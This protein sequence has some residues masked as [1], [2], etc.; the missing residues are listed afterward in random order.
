MVINLGWWLRWVQAG[1]M[2][3]WRRVHGVRIFHKICSCEIRETL[4]EQV[5]LI[6]ER[7][8]QLGWLI[9]AWP[10]CSR[11]DWRGES[12][13]YRHGKA[14]QRSSKDKVRRLH[15][16]PGLIP[17][18]YGASR[19]AK[20]C[21]KRQVLRLLRQ[22]PHVRKTIVKR[23]WRPIENARGLQITR[24]GAFITVYSSLKKYCFCR[25]FHR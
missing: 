16:R 1:E 25:L 19:T 14:P 15:L 10:A 4:N 3:F 9:H 24:S 13:G 18:C 5:I 20:S 12:S 2:G 21:W 8:I 22:R 17:S 7:D 23:E 11:K 6:R